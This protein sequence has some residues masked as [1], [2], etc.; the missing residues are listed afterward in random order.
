MNFKFSLLTI[1]F[2]SIISCQKDGVTTIH[3]DLQVVLDEAME[4]NPTGLHEKVS[5]PNLDLTNWIQNRQQSTGLLESS[6]NSDFTSLYDNALAAIFFINEGQKENAEKIF[7]Y[8]LSI[9][10]TE[11][12]QN[13]GFY[14]FRKSDGTHPERI[15]M[16]DNAWIL[17]ALNHY[18]DKYQSSQYDNLAQQLENWLRSLQ[19]EGGGL[20]GGINSDG[21]EIPLVTEGVITAFH[22]VRGYDEFHKNILFFL[23]QNR[24]DADLGLLMAWPEN[25]EYTYALDVLSLSKGIFKDLSDDVLFQANRFLNEQ[26]ATIT[27]ETISGYCFDEDKDVVWL[28]GTAQMAVAFNGIQRFDLSKKIIDNLEKTIINSTITQNSKGLPYTAN[29]G[30]SYGESMLWDHTDITPALSATIWYSFA[31]TGFN[32]FQLDQKSM[33]PEE[34]KFWLQNQTAKF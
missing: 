20:L 17:I 11:L 9:S 1:V 4:N 5:S 10:E 13:G 3:E 31:K 34:D 26:T 25:P 28:E 6:E 7:D 21:S 16:G 27:G 15:W 19:V 30:T 23:G 32:P 12:Q 2:I 29:Y 14:Q 8:Y 24:W 18:S 33:I 22:A